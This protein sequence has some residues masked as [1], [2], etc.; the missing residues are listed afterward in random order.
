MSDV[1]QTALNYRNR[2]KAEISK[3]EDFLRMAEEFSKDRDFESRLA[4]AKVEPGT[5]GHAQGHAQG[6]A[7]GQSPVD[8]LR[9][10]SKA[11]S[12]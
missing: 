11:A 8:R 6:Q 10:A 2:L 4:F 9:P 1:L 5:Q 12:A 7:Q 3:V